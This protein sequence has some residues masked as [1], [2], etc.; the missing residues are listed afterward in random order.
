MDD[1]THPVHQPDC[2][3]PPISS[4]MLQLSRGSQL[5]LGRDN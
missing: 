5:S 4:S 3:F 2:V 1:A